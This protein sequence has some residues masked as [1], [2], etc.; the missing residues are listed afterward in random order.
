[1]LFITHK[2]QELFELADRC[3]VLRNGAVVGTVDMP[4]ATKQQLTEMMVGRDVPITSR[5]QKRRFGSPVMS[6]KDLTVTDEG[7]RLLDGVTFEIREK[8]V[9]GVA[10]V[11]GNGQ[12]ILIEALLGIRESQEGSVELHGDPC[13]AMTPR[14]F[15]ERGG[16]IIPEDRRAAG[17]AASMTIWENLALD[18]IGD[19]AVSRRGFLR[20]QHAVRAAG[21]VISEYK[22]RTT[23][24]Y[25][26]MRQ[27]SGGNQQ[28]V[29]L[30][31]EFARA[32]AFLLASQPTRGLDVEA[33]A[34]VWQRLIES[35]EAGTA[36]LLISAELEEIFALSHRI[37]VMV[38]G[39]FASV[40]DRDEASIESIGLLMAGEQRAGT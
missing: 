32:P 29:V 33:A 40:L 39:R 10:G 20:K 31:R 7:R 37:A 6:V 38:G 26:E 9:L 34:F 17:M 23:G 4:L 35:S 15:R 12:D 27:L 11:A 16:A 14:M 5:P 19:H 3:T 1:V 8:E 24:P 30:A 21:Q 25:A 2:L 18:K 13:P 28:K 36:V 22:I